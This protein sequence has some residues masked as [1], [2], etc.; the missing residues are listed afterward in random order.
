MKQQLKRRPRRQQRYRLISSTVLVLLGFGLG[1]GL[2]FQ[3]KA[4]SEQR[5]LCQEIISSQAVLSRQQLTQL[6]TVPERENRQAIEAITA[7]PYCTLTAIEVR[8]GV[9]AERAAYPLAFDPNTWLVVLY[10]D[11][12]YVGYGFRLQH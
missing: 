8:A 10:E 4:A 11:E 7:D 6:L 5:D 12:E 1:L 9:I 2:R 3:A